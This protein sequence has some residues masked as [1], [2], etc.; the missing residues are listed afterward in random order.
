MPKK[1]TKGQALTEREVDVLIHIAN[2]LSNKEVASALNISVRTVE[3]HR[4]RII[5]K[6]DIHSVAGLTRYALQAKLIALD[7]TLTS[8]EATPCAT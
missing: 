4:E 8:P 6:L 5:C 2:G 7:A 3:T 1:A